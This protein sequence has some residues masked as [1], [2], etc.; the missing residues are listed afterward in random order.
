MQLLK[1][2][3]KVMNLKLFKLLHHKRETH[4]F[5][6]LYFLH[7]GAE[8][9]NLDCLVIKDSNQFTFCVRAKKTIKAEGRNVYKGFYKFNKDGKYSK[10]V[11]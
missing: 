1:R 9:K 7:I 6:R 4:Y 3:A 10:S 11:V 8:Q 5:F 2:P